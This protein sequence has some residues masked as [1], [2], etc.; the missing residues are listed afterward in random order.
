MRI[1]FWMYMVAV[2]LIVGAF[3]ATFYGAQVAQEREHCRVEDGWGMDLTRL[4]RVI[5]WDTMPVEE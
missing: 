5:I 2:P 1:I 4:G 3:S